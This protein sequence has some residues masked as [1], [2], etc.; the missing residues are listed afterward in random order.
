[1]RDLLFTTIYSKGKTVIRLRGCFPPDC[2]IIT[3]ARQSVEIKQNLTT[4][5]FAITS[6]IYTLLQGQRM[7]FELS[8]L[9]N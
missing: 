3:M 1:M 4:S 6:V 8:E 9:L 2:T 7:V 5:N